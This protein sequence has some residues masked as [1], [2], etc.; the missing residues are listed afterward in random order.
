MNP[1]LELSRL[2]IH[3]VDR[4][5]D[6]PICAPREQDV[7]DLHPTI[8]EFILDLASEVWDAADTGTTRSGNF[9]PDEHERLGPSLVKHCLERIVHDDE[10]F[11][12][13]SEDLALHLYHRSHPQASPGLL[14][15]TRLVSPENG[16]IFVHTPGSFSGFLC[17]E[18]CDSL[19]C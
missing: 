1:R 9:V 18:G 17:C 12:A 6:G 19:F 2:A 11:F 3:Y 16:G 13:A 8:I 4:S 14:A 7:A 5:T 10:G 15:V